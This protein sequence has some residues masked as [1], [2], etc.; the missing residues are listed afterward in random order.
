MPRLLRRLL[1]ALAVLALILAAAALWKR[2]EIGRL[3][4]VNSLFAPENIVENFSQM[5]QLFLTRPLSRGEGPVSPLSKGPEA[6]LV[7]EVQAWI[8]DRS[9]TAMVV[10]K[11]GQMVHESYHLG[12][13]PEDLRISW[14]VAK[15]FLSALFG[16]IEAEGA[17]GSL[18]DQVVQYAPLLKGSA[19]DGATIRDV[20]TM[21]SGVAFNE[22]YLD[23]NSDINK[24]GRVLALGG[25]M[26]GFAAGLKTRDAEPGARFHYVSIDT[27]VLG[28]VIR[29]ATGK[30]IPELLETRILA[31]MGFE[32]APY[33]LTDGE[34]VSF[35]L[36]GMNMQTRDYARFGQMVLQGGEWQGVQVVPEAWVLAM[37]SPQAEDGSAYGFQWWIPDNATPGEV[38]AQGIYGQY[39]YINP[40]LGVVIAVNSADRGFEEPGVYD[41]NIAILRAIAAGLPTP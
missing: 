3:L 26:D 21:S 34:G 7:P 38:M 32:T 9:V 8:K 12:T 36:G 35:V 24:M 23:F 25:S 6:T 29:G 5:D 27:H 37:T 31:P 39:I 14:S 28:M 40:G 22:D 17:I 19:Y 15:S 10:L 16:V 11:T 2:E 13:K 18:D 20:L 30:D 1:Q 4:A 41:G 33:Y